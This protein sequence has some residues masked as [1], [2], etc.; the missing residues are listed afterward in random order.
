MGGNRPITFF[1]PFRLFDS[2]SPNPRGGALSDAS[3]VLPVKFCVIFTSKGF[4]TTYIY[5][6]ASDHFSERGRFARETFSLERENGSHPPRFCF[7]CH[8]VRRDPGGHRPGGYRF[9]AGER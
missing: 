9:A 7:C 5:P 2:F 1:I 4:C 3:G 6:I 8:C